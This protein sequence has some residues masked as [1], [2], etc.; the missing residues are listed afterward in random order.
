MDNYIF[1][2]RE[3]VKSWN[4]VIAIVTMIAI[5]HLSYET[6]LHNIITFDP[7]NANDFESS[8]YI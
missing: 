5:G 2:F 3:A 1:V 4:E 7:Q 6:L 8:F